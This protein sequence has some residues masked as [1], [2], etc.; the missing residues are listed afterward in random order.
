MGRQEDH[1]RRILAR[2]RADDVV[3]VLLFRDRAVRVEGH[4]EFRCLPEC[5]L[6]HCG[7]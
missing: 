4:P 3:G 1:L 6:Q 2:D 7:I 5:L